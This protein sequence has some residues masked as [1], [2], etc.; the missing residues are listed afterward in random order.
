MLT[1]DNP[2]LRKPDAEATP[3]G[4]GVEAL[5]QFAKWVFDEARD[6]SDLCGGDVQDKGVELGLLLEVAVTDACGP[7][8]PCAEFGFPLTCYRDGPLLAAPPEG[9]ARAWRPI[10]T[11]PKDGEVF[12]GYH[13]LWGA[14]DVR[15]KPYVANGTRYTWVSGD[16]TTAWPDEC[17]SHWMPLPSAP[18]GAAHG[19]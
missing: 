7:C 1:S 18:E 3:A 6:G 5:R 13:T 10:V 17:L 14:M 19:G 15:Y 4:V 11:A 2:D 8:C 9:A 16:Y 12:L